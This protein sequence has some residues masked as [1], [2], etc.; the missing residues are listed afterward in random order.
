MDIIS[1]LLVVA[2]LLGALLGA[3]ALVSPEWAA[4]FVR[5]KADPDQPDGYAEFRATFGGVFLMMHVAFLGAFYMGA[6]MIGAAG[7]LCAAWAGA[8]GGRLVSLVLDAAKGVR[9]KHNLVSLG[10]EIVVAIIF[11]LPVID[12]MTSTPG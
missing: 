2:G 10:V 12:F 7:V 4:R 9:T 6:G 5:L 8:A 3:A 11:A 1:I